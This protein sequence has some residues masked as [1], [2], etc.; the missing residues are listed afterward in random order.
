MLSVPALVPRLSCVVVVCLPIE[1]ICTVYSGACEIR[2][3][4][5]PAG[6]WVPDWTANAAASLDLTVETE[7]DGER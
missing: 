4:R 6:P 5:D 1:V 7:I 2:S 3:T